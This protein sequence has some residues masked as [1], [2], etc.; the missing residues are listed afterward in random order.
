MEPT[1]NRRNPSS[2]KTGSPAG[3]SSQPEHPNSTA[4]EITNKTTT[5]PPPVDP[6]T[7]PSVQYHT[8]FTSNDRMEFDMRR[9][10][11]VERQPSTSN[12]EIDTCHPIPQPCNPQIS[13]PNSAPWVPPHL[14]QGSSSAPKETTSTE[15][16]NSN[17][18]RSRGRSKSSSRHQRKYPPL[19]GETL[20]V[21]GP[22][23]D[24]SLGGRSGV[25][26]IAVTRPDGT[27]GFPRD[28]QYYPDERVG[29]VDSSSSSSD[30]EDDDDDDDGEVYGHRGCLP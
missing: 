10:I 12:G 15:P 11:Y 20:H 9:A 23:P 19:L 16:D 24:G 5:S 21:P 2:G 29:E 17:D 28:H 18:S 1:R 4:K 30:D 6:Y 13:P 7:L 8:N 14:Q 22:K 26:T 25:P 27:V 3:P